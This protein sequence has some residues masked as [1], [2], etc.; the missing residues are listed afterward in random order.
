ML[1]NV[2]LID[3]ELTH[4]VPRQVTATTGLDALTQVIEPYVSNLANPLTDGF[5]IEAI[6]RAGR[7][8]RR[9]YQKGHDA[10]ARY[11]MALVSLLGGLALANAKLG[12]VHGFAGTLGGMFDAPH[13]GICAALLSPVMEANIKALDERQPRHSHRKRFDTVGKMLTG[14]P[15]AT[16]TDGL[17]WV[18]ETVNL[19]EIPSLSS[20][21]I[22]EDHFLTIIERS[23][24]SSSMKGNP[25]VLTD[26]EMVGILKA[27]L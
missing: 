3:P 14:N 11:D 24:T 17:K 13:G 25:L 19:L 27:A 5:C 18:R 10:K 23:R 22:T 1:P 16:A 2:A 21:G 4:S 7:A 9:V 8:L 20:Y 15:G 6:P 12:A 26:E